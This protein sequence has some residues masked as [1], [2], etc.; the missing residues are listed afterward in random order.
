MLRVNG[1]RGLTLLL[2]KPW[3]S[4]TVCMEASLNLYIM[5]M[6]GKLR[7]FLSSSF[8]FFMG[9]EFSTK[10]LVLAKHVLST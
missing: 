2:Q 3:V 1:H 5:F 6:L 9:L 7:L 4:D 10:G 8:F